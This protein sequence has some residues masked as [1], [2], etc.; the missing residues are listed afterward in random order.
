MWPSREAEKQRIVAALRNYGATVRRSP[1]LADPRAVDTLAMQF[2][3]EPSSGGLLQGRT[4]EADLP[5]PG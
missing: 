4:A 3:A 1:G 2:I 5:E